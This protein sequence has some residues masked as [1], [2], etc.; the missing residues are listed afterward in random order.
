[1]RWT[2]DTCEKL[3][4]DLPLSLRARHLVPLGAVRVLGG[5][6]ALARA[7][8]VAQH[9]QAVD[10][11]L[12]DVAVLEEDGRLAGKADAGRSAGEDYVAGLQRHHVREVGDDL[13]D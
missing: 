1:M 7:D 12:H 4:L 13:G 8:R 5:K 3:R 11:D 6:E 9:A 10:L 2:V